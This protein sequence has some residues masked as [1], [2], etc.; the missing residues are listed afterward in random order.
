MEKL[1]KPNLKTVSGAIVAIQILSGIIILQIVIV[2]IIHYNRAD[3]GYYSISTDGAKT[4]IPGLPNPNVSTKALLRWATL[5]A[6]SCYTINF[7]EYEQNLS[8]LRK[9]FT[10]KGYASYLA[11]IE[12]SGF[13]ADILKQKLIVSA[14][15]YGP[16]VVVS[17][18]DNYGRY[19]WRIQVPLLLTYQGAGK[20]TREL[21]KV[22][23]LLVTTVS[24]K[25]SSRGIGVEQITEGPMGRGAGG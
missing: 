14:V 19:A 4:K 18:G 8:D 23:T 17:E 22:I 20:E 2:F 3:P 9:Y 6:T 1:K 13:L 11:S 24:P 10:D 16:T 7:A 5:A 12:D 21:T 25:E 15:S